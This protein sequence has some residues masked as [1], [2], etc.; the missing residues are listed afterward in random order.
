MIRIGHGYD[1]H[2]IVQDRGLVLGGVP[3]PWD[4]GLLGHSDA[5]VLLHAITDAVLGALALGD[6]GYWFPDTDAEWAGA[7]SANLLRNV[8]ADPR[9]QPWRLSNLDA[10][11]QAERPKLAPHIGPIRRS[12]AAIFSV[13][14]EAI[15][16]KAT[17]MEGAGAI[18]QGE[19]M[20]AHA[21]LVLTKGEA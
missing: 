13:P 20:A 5:D 10:T 12:V 4:R 3:I 21:V 8:L 1:L 19:A 14:E 7:D 2:R 6:I 9:V 15:S 16:V 18:G 11:I 17:T